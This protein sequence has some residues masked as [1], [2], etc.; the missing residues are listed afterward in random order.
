MAV[1]FSIT[2]FLGSKVND[3]PNGSA[4]WTGAAGGGVG[5]CDAAGLSAGDLVSAG[6]GT[7]VADG[8]GAGVGLGLAAGAGEADGDWAGAG[9]ASAIAAK[10]S[11]ATR[12]ARSVLIRFIGISP[13]P[14]SDG[15]S[16]CPGAHGPRG[17]IF[18]TREFCIRPM[19][20]VS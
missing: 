12:A 10:G 9:L 7:G 13:S 16:I 17:A 19:T 5:D 1:P 11:S 14:S 18:L 2:T 8:V 4:V 3:S 20:D 6:G 15:R